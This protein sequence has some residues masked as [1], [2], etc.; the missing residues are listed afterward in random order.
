M[1]PT[2]VDR[3]GT[4]VVVSVRSERSDVSPP[5]PASGRQ[6][7]GR[8]GLLGGDGEPLVAF[9]STTKARVPLTGV[10]GDGFE[11]LRWTSGSTFFGLAR[12]DSEPRAVLRCDLAA[13]RCATL[14]RLAA[15]DSP[16]FES[17][18]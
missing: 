4:S 1:P 5:P 17:G 8:F 16:V 18:T 3:L 7:P 11:L 14:G 2:V 12:L 15:G 9:L 6:G 10:P 13:Q